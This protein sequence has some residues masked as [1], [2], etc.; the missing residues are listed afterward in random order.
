MEP[1]EEYFE[2]WDSS[3]GDRIEPTPHAR[4]EVQLISTPLSEEPN[5][6]CCCT[7]H[8]I[9]PGR[10]AEFLHYTK[11]QKPPEGAIKESLLEEPYW[12]PV[13][14]DVEWPRVSDLEGRDWEEDDE[15]EEHDERE[16]DDEGAYMIMRLIPWLYIW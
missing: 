3:A 2:D 12:L 6:L 7:K 1:P 14:C 15:R 13:R 16:E 4:M 5:D 9:G 11:T 10:K 8:I